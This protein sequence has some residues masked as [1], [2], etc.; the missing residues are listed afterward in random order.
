MRRRSSRRPKDR[1]E[2]QLALLVLQLQLLPPLHHL[3]MPFLRAA[4]LLPLLLPPLPLRPVLLLMTRQLSQPL[5]LR[6]L[7]LSLAS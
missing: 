4:L 6:K 3:L 1:K 5:A 7:R 2:A